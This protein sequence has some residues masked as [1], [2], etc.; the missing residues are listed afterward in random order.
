MQLNTDSSLPW[1]DAGYYLLFVLSFLFLFWFRKGW[2]VQWIFAGVM[3]FTTLTPNT[4]MANESISLSNIWLTTQQQ[5]YIAYN[6]EKYLEAAVL[7]ED[8]FWI[9]MSYYKAKNYKKAH[10]FF[11]RVDN[12]EGMIYAAN[13]LANAREYLLARTMYTEILKID[14]ENE[15]V[16]FNRKIIQDLIDAVNLMSESQANTENEVS[17][18]LGDEPQTGD[19]AE[20]QVSKAQLKVEF[21]TAEELMQD[22][23]LNKK[24]M[25]RVQA[26]P[27]IF[28]YNKFQRQLQKEED[29]E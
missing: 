26:N 2:V 23:E 15:V 5:G 18:D 1:E 28:L 12:I 29:G 11:L 21:I 8:P 25:E 20:E 3:V 14:P 24:W 10:S 16:L 22:E 27:S 7:Y 6:N 9:G 13:S 19:G 4:A 17:K